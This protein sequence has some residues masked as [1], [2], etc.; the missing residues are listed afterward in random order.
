[1]CFILNKQTLI[2]L[3][4]YNDGKTIIKPYNIDDL[5][6]F[7]HLSLIIYI[8]GINDIKCTRLAIDR[9]SCIML[10]LFQYCTMALCYATCY[11]HH[12]VID[13]LKQRYV[14]DNWTMKHL[15]NYL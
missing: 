4:R 12:N 7:G 5:V 13:V 8:N 1:M 2:R 3:Q 11:G 6:R 15:H 9:A 14:F 10:W